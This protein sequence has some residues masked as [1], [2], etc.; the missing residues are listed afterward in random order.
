[1][2]ANRLGAYEKVFHKL[3]PARRTK[4]MEGK[5]PQLSGTRGI[6]SGQA[7]E[8]RKEVAGSELC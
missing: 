3:Q 6:S 4:G 2:R 8:E 1:M 5:I 7:S